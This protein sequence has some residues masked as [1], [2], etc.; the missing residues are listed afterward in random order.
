MTI[1]EKKTVMIDK[2]TILQL[3][4]KTISTIWYKKFQLTLNLIQLQYTLAILSMILD[5]KKFFYQAKQE[6]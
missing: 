3:H 1:V 4:I 5:D 2:V 6:E